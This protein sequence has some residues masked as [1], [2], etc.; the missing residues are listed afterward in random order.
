[1]ATPPMPP[2]TLPMLETVDVHRRMLSAEQAAK[3]IA[4]W[5]SSDITT[6]TLATRFHVSESTMRRVLKGHEK[7]CLD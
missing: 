4:L 3:A 5:C 1:M 7:E 6:S 2:E